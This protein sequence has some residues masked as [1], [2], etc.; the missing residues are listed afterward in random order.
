MEI[1][2]QFNFSYYE[3]FLNKKQMFFIDSRL[4]LELIYN[5]FL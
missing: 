2:S 3:Q 4:V 5:A 1:M